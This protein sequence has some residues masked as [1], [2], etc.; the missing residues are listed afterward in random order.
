VLLSELLLWVRSVMA[1]RILRPTGS[2][3]GRGHLLMDLLHADL[4]LKHLVV[5]GY[6]LIS[7]LSI[8]ALLRRWSTSC[9]LRWSLG[10]WV[11]NLLL[12]VD[13]I[14][15]HLLLELLLVLVLLLLVLGVH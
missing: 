6:M 9:C 11:N 4:G 14:L 13:G 10:A 5:S 3:L 2:L 12:E 15:T 1:Q 8:E 7:W